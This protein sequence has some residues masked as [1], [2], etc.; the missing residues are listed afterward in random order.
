MKVVLVEWGD[1]DVGCGV[2]GRG[3]HQEEWARNQ[4]LRDKGWRLGLG[5]WIGN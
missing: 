1:G 4:R 5:H 2:G 3:N